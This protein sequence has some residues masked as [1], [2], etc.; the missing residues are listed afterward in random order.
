MNDV[1]AQFFFQGHA[2]PPGILLGHVGADY[3]FAMQESITRIVK[4]ENI[5]WAVMT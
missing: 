5:R 2:V 1:T 3:Q 4:G